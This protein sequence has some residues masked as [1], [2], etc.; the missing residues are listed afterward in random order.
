MDSARSV[1]MMM[2]VIVHAG[3]VF[4]V[5]GYWLV[6]ADNPRIWITTLIEFIALFNVEGFFVVSGIFTVMTAKRH[7]AAALGDRRLKRLLVPLLTTAIVLNVPF[8]LMMRQQGLADQPVFSLGYLSGGWVLHLWFL[9]NLVFYTMIMR[10][11]LPVLLPLAQRLEPRLRLVQKRTPK[12]TRVMVLL[13]AVS[14]AQLCLV[15]ISHFMPVMYAELFFGSSLYSFLHHFMFFLLGVTLGSFPSL[16][17]SFTRPSA[18]LCAAAIALIG[19]S[20]AVTGPASLDLLL[21]NLKVAFVT[22]TLIQCLFA[23]FTRFLNTPSPVWQHLSGASYSIYLLHHPIVVLLAFVIFRTEW[24]AEA[25]FAFILTGAFGISWLIHVT[26]IARS[27]LLSFLFNGKNMSR[28]DAAQA[29]AQPRD[30]PA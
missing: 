22:F 25:E 4:D 20:T 19:V 14:L 21:D 18:L 5:E 1:L 26:L 10:V 7:G 11:S 15:A 17:N 3:A 23:L 30:K 16:W 8:S 13:G 6:T 2:V 9:V 29:A 28:P 12:G 24:P 27:P